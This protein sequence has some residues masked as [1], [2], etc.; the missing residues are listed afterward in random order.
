MPYDCAVNEW[1]VAMASTKLGN[2]CRDSAPS[3]ARRLFATAG[4][5][6]A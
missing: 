2:R 6:G 5:P 3:A 1:V 4:D